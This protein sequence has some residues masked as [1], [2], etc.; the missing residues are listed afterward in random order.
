MAIAGDSAGSRA[1]RGRWQASV[2]GLIVLVLVAGVVAAVTRGAREVWG[3]RIVTGDRAPGT[4]ASRTQSVPIERTAGLVVEVAGIFL[5]LILAR[6]ILG[7][8]RRLPADRSIRG[9]VRA[10]AI[11][12]RAM[13]I[14][15]PVWFITKESQV[16]LIDL[17]F[18][19]EHAR[20]IVIGNGRYRAA[21]SLFPV[22]GVIAMVG[23]L[24][25]AGAGSFL[26]EP[27]PLR[28]RPVTLFAILAGLTGVLIIAAPNSVAI[29]AYLVLISLEAVT[30]AMYHRPMAGPGLAARLL[31]A[32]IH[33]GVA[34]LACMALAVVLARDFERARR[35]EPWATI[36]RA[37][38]LRLGLLATAAALGLHVALVTI[39][40]INAN[41]AE[42]FQGILGPTEVG[43]IL[44]GVGLLAAGMAARTLFSRPAGEKPV[45]LARV[46][47]GIRWTILGVGVLWFLVNAT[48]SPTLDPDTPRVIRWVFAV[49]DSITRMWGL[50]PDAFV[51]GLFLVFTVSN[52]LWI[53][54]GLGMVLL[55][56]EL[57]IG[58][59]ASDVAPFDR[60]A[61]E[62]A[63]VRR[64][65]WLVIGLVVVC[66]AALPTFFVAGQSLLNLRFFAADWWEFGWPR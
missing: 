29:V 58:R 24:L 22:C 53:M 55:L 2:G 11:A 57:A 65:L 36:R 63:L 51:A 17:Q 44:S 34:W 13:A 5:I 12:W 35:G 52:V 27:A 60:L 43:M 31:G 28:R 21:Q 8:L 54:L 46:S 15:F 62:P 4:A 59:A 40:A 25:G 56:F 45:W 61:I 14:G 48:G 47:I 32:G 33:A 39:P 66:L 9:N 64:F 26:D 38:F 19:I 41:L 30:N 6:S 42:G 10:W 20:S 23:L 49:S 3:Q 7:L 1:R 50:L 37:W 16:L 18:E